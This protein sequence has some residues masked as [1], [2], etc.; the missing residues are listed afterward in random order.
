MDWKY[1]QLYCPHCKIIHDFKRMTWWELKGIYIGLYET[2]DGKSQKS[3]EQ[4]LIFGESTYEKLI[5]YLN[6]KAAS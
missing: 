4:E 1:V 3:C 6:Q 5:P 2:A